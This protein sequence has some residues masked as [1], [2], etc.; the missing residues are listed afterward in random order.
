VREAWEIVEPGIDYVHGKHVD[1]ICS[2]LEHVTRTRDS[3][4]LINI[5]P[6]CMKSLLVGVF[7]PAWVWGPGAW[8][9]A[10][11]MFA[12]YASELSTRDS[13]KTRAIVESE[14]YRREWPAV[15]LL[16]DEN[17][18]TRFSNTA[19]GWRFATSVGGPG[20]GEHPDFKCWDDP[21]TVMQADSDVQRQAALDWRDG[22]LATRGKTRGA[23][24]VG[25]MQRVHELDLSAHV[26]AKGG[27]DHVMLPMRFEPDRACE[28]D[29][30]TEDGEL[31][32]PELFPEYRVAELERE[33]GSLRAAGQLQQRPAPPGGSIFQRPWFRVFPTAPRFS[34]A[35]RYWDKAGTKDGGDYTVG[36]LIAERDR[37]WFVLDVVRG[38]WG[39]HERE[40]V[41]QT[42]A[43]VDEKNFPDY[44][45]IVEEEGGS[46]GKESAARTI[47]MLAGFRVK[48]D[49]V[50]G[51]KETRWE[52][53]AAQ[54]EAGNVYLIAG[55]WNQSFIDEH[56]IAP[57]GKHDD[58]IDAASGA[59]NMLNKSKAINLEDWLDKI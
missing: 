12:S 26:L 5:P 42:Q 23:R 29:W 15:Q 43:K 3:K 19:G 30:R 34:R 51:K 54:L 8:Q 4:L 24:E 55:D 31:L 33:M 10:R 25:V 48:A 53:W 9:Q 50:T 59:F 14:W 1:V 32:W 7:W 27:W 52:P 45:V 37:M 44:Q 57:N 18:K 20:T 41:I 35:L 46:G 47:K 38:Q 22:T 28:Y 13:L 2:K 49:R 39:F 56:L 17:R 11:W 40:Q 21:H 36:A 58:Q 6:G 16:P